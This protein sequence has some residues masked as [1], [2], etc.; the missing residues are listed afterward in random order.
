MDI[1]LTG[2]R[3]RSTI[4]NTVN[5]DNLSD[6]ENLQEVI[7]E[8]FAFLDMMGAELPQELIDIIEEYDSDS[9]D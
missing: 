9:G 5:I 8:F 7:L 3:G 1:T 6:E 2:K 4:K